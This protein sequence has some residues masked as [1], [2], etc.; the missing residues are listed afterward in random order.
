MSYYE[1]RYLPSAVNVVNPISLCSVPQGFVIQD[2]PFK[3][4]YN[5][6]DHL[7]PARS[8]L[9]LPFVKSCTYMDFPATSF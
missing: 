5:A 1:V 3:H 6:T 2:T 9:S 8:D 4:Q 7:P